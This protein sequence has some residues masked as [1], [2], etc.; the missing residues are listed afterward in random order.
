[1]FKRFKD[2]IEQKVYNMF[3][4]KFIVDI[5]D[6]SGGVRIIPAAT[7][8]KFEPTSKQKGI[9]IEMGENIGKALKQ[10]S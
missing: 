9:T 10:L 2:E 6:V 3:G 8:N 7:H 4:D 5:D 1:M